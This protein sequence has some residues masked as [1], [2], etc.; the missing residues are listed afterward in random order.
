MWVMA[1]KSMFYLVLKILKH[2]KFTLKLLLRM[3][4]ESMSATTVNTV[5]I[6]I[7]PQLVKILVISVVQ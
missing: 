1:R 5:D 7:I 3:A 6:S 2:M 4:I